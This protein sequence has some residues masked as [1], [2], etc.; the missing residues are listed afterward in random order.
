MSDPHDAR[1]V[2]IAD[3]LDDAPLQTADAAS[4]A[5]TAAWVLVAYL[6][7]LALIAFWPVPVDRD[8]AG[9]VHAILRAIPGLSYPALEFTANIVLFVPFGVLLTLAA[10]HRRGLVMPIALATTLV[11]E[12]GQ[13]LLLVQRTPSVLDIIANVTG[14]AI[15]LGAVVLVER[16]RARR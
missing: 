1:A 3:A 8:A 2:A 7:A 9:L 10:P 12:T 15:G 14:A 16:L 11:I 5:R 6:T 13:A 4:S